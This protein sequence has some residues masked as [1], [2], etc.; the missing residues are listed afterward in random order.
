MEKGTYD[1]SQSSADTAGL[2]T[3]VESQVLR[4][5][6]VLRSFAELWYEWTSDWPGKYFWIQNRI[7]WSN[8][9]RRTIFGHGGQIGTWTVTFNG[10]QKWI[11]Y[12]KTAV[13][14][15]YVVNV[16]FVLVINNDET[17]VNKM[18]VT[19]ISRYLFKY[20][21]KKMDFHKRNRRRK[22]QKFFCWK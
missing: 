10:G 21:S 13:K 9:P 17:S 4:W 5:D 3:A 2:D 8:R 1:T 16:I 12:V 19:N 15:I 7:L 11:R 22:F 20:F 6:H 14:T 18:S